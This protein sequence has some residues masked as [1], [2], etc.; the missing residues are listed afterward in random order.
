LELSFFDKIMIATVSIAFVV[1]LMH[2]MLVDGSPHSAMTRPTSE[3]M[4]Q[5]AQGETSSSSYVNLLM[6]GNSYTSINNLTDTIQSMLHHENSAVVNVTNYT[7]GAAHLKDYSDPIDPF[8]NVLKEQPW[9]WVVLQ[10]QSEI[11]GLFYTE[12]ADEWIA[13]NEAIMLLDQAIRREGAGT[14]LFQT[15]GRLHHDDNPSEA[16]HRMYDSYDHH[17]S[18]IIEGYNK[19]QKMLWT[20]DRPV[21]IAPVGLAFKAIHD[22][23]VD[24]GLDP[25]V[26]G[27]EFSLLYDEDASH[28]SIR[29]SYLAACVI[30]G[31]ITGQEVNKYNWEAPGIDIRVQERLRQVAATTISTFCQSCYH[32]RND[33]P[34]IPKEQQSSSQ[35]SSH[36]SSSSFSRILLFTFVA[37]V[38]S[39]AWK[40]RD[41]LRH[42]LMPMTDRNTSMSRDD[43]EYSQ[44]SSGD[45]NAMAMELTSNPQ[46]FHVE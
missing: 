28:P 31:T 24:Q 9:N 19:Y 34:Y 17:Q 33:K 7:I 35:S 36:S 25:E 38:G 13:S 43:F 15:W 6:V 40:K 44:L 20:M 32:T 27:G 42:A 10:E 26:D 29:G 8:E 37:L 4:R 16:I 21:L 41:H 46:I 12:L 3:G 22:A 30:I 11:P 18:K 45:T 5:R 14:I 2:R 1:C 39:L 23:M